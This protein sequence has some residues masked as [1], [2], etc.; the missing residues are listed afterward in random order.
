MLKNKK[1]SEIIKKAPPKKGG[2]VPAEKAV[3]ITALFCGIF[4]FICF[5][6]YL[7]R[8][9]FFPEGKSPAILAI[10]VSVC[11]ALPLAVYK[12]L[13]RKLP[14]T[15]FVLLCIYTALALFFCITFVVHLWDTWLFPAADSPLSEIEDGAVLI[16]FGSKILGDRPA[17]PLA[18][19][20]N[21]AIELIKEKPDML[22]IVSGG[23]GGDEIMP[24]AVVMKNYLVANGIAE[25]RIITETESHN[26]V[27]NIDNSKAILKSLGLE[28]RQIA[29]VSTRFHI[30]RIKQLMARAGFED[31]LYF[32]APSPTA[33]SLIFSLIREYCSRAKII[34]GSY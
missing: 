11:A 2:A 21:K 1:T 13:K 6:S 5:F 3:W 32:S 24:E 4:I 10:L 14:R 18:Y 19:R 16:V 12:P 17:K 34:L 23:Q 31:A 7:I 28:D 20:L 27:Q 9:M 30:P 22:C 33:G 26:T 29:C 15:A 8:Q 25:E